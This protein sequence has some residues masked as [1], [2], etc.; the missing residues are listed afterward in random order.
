MGQGT[1][2]MAAIM[3]DNNQ[4]NDTR[5]NKKIGC[6]FRRCYYCP[7]F[8]SEETEWP[9]A[10]GATYSV[11]QPFS[12]TGTPGTPRAPAAYLELGARHQA[13]LG[14]RLGHQ[15]CA[16]TCYGSVGG[17]RPLSHVCPEF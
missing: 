4:G 9:C 14:F 7:H 17:L 15:V 12:P 13:Q 11:T 10:D 16:P 2:V 1:A 5:R 6:N 8:T 3:D